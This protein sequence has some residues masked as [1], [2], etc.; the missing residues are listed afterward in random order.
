M[1]IHNIQLNSKVNIPNIN[2]AIGNFD[3]VHLGHQKIINELIE[4]SKMQNC[5]SAILSFQPHPRQFF[6]KEYRNFQIISEEKK[7]AY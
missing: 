2:L 3:G 7:F 5:S 1:Q 4:N 6:S